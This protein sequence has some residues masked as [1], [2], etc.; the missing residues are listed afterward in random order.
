MRLCPLFALFL[1]LTARAQMNRA[2]T[3]PL[4]PFRIADNLC[5]VGS[6]DLAAYLVTTLAGNILINAKAKD[7]IVSSYAA[8]GMM[9]RCD[10]VK[11]AAA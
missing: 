9:A 3:T 4:R 7:V 2:W 11:P 1:A 6:Q 8:P 10:C 5:Y